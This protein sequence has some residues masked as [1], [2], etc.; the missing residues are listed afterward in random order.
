MVSAGVLYVATKGLKSVCTY[1]KMKNKSNRL[2]SS[3]FEKTHPDTLD[4]FLLASECFIFIGSFD[5]PWFG[6]G[7]MR[8]VTHTFYSRLETVTPSLA[9]YYSWNQFIYC[10]PF[11]L[12]SWLISF[13][14]PMSNKEELSLKVGL[15]IHPEIQPNWLK[16]CQLLY[17]K[18]LKPWHNFHKFS[19]LFKGTVN[20]VIYTSYIYIYN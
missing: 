17:Q 1:S 6:T 15:K 14:F 18:V 8:V 13:D 7:S 20:E 16:L 5:P 3:H 12:G 4:R 10:I 9:R 2:T 19:K 11:S